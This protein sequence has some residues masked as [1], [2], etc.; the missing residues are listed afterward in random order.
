LTKQPNSVS[1]SRMER[2][3]DHLPPLTIHFRRG[4]GGY[5]QMRSEITDRFWI[6]TEFNTFTIED[7]NKVKE[8]LGEDFPGFKIMRVKD[9][10]FDA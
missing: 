1:T 6:N 4:W 2:E 10:E 5:W 9:A 8:L 3:Y 7:E